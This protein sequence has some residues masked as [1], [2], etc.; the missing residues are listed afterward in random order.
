[1]NIKKGRGEIKDEF[2]AIVE[3]EEVVFLIEVKATPKIEYIDA[4]KAIKLES[5]KKL[6]PEEVKLLLRKVAEHGFYDGKQDGYYVGCQ[7]SYGKANSL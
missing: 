1:M 6:F 3:C 7:G 5:F 4:F 2:D